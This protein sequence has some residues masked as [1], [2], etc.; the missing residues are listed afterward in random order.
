MQRKILL[1]SDNKIFGFGGGSLE[2]HKYYNGLK[3]YANAHHDEIKV[4]SIDEPFEDSFAGKIAKNRKID[5]LARLCGHSTFMYFVWKKYREQV[6]AYK[7]DILVLG[8]SRMGFV[9]KDIRKHLPSCKIICNMENVEYDYVKGYFSDKKSG[10]KALYISLEQWCTKRDEKMAI[11]FSDALDYLTNRDYKRTH[12]LYSVEEKREMILPI[13]IEKATELTMTS[14]KKTVV[15]IG[16][17]NYGSNVNALMEFIQTVWKPHYTQNRELAF[18]IGGSNPNEK[19]RQAIKELPN[20]TLYENFARLEDIVPKGAM[21]IAPIQKGAGMKVKVAETLSM[22]LMVA[23]S[24]EA[25][26]GY[27]K[28]IAADHLNGILR[29]NTVDE[30]ISTIKKYLLMSGADLEKIEQQ[31]KSIYSEYYSYEVSRKAIAGML[32]QMLAGGE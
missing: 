19:L 22:G 9:A 11:K 10:L 12:E 18:V 24:D 2:E 25:L 16:S 17:L 29:V 5:L 26:V 27:E 14:D 23:A 31:N 8:R 4:I 7:P 28:A 32:D 20:C 6:I 13:C 15:F 1:L 3:R 21:V 30:Y